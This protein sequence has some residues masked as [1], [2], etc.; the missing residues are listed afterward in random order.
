MP[1]T[2]V[3]D[4][5]GPTVAFPRNFLHIKLLADNYPQVDHILFREEFMR[6]QLLRSFPAEKLIAIGREIRPGRGQW[7]L[8]RIFAANR[9]YTRE[10]VAQIAALTPARIILFLE[11]EP[12]EL[13][14]IDHF[15]I[16][17]F[18]LWEEGVMHYVDMNNPYLFRLRR[19]VQIACGF[20]PGHPFLL[21]L[22]R[23]RITVRDRFDKCNL[24]MR[25]PEG[26]NQP[27]EAIAFV[28]NVLVAD[29]H[30]TRGNYIKA[31]GKLVE[32]A[33]VPVVY[34]PHPREGAEEIAAIGA[35]LDG[36]RFG[37]EKPEGGSLQHCLDTDYRLYLSPF[38]T[39]LLDLQKF[40]KSYW[41]PQHFAL[42]S[43][44]RALRSTDRFPVKALTEEALAACLSA[45]APAEA[46][47]AS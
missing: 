33:P 24:R 1:D 38:S 20:Y 25:I 23:D 37:I 12:L 47:A 21:R 46:G 36:P 44:D 35:A 4:A 32:M 40:S 17:R 22:P 43:Y 9:R 11:N 3:P 16:E 30:I 29:G 18:E 34:L 14:L 31:L 8:P 13:A 28:A 41:I 42:G 39:T 5:N 27:R 6:A 15:G 45:A 2:I 26:R 19:M 7:N 10:K